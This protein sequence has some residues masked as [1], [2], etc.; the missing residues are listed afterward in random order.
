MITA[1]KQGKMVVMKGWPGFNWTEKEIRNV[2]YETLLARAKEN[3][4]FPLACFLVAAQEHSYFCYTWGYRE[5]HGSLDWYDEFE[6]PL[7]SP[8]ADAI[9]NGWI[10]RRSF[11]HADVWVNL[12]MK[13]AKID[14]Y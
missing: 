5:N 12:E 7:G 8:K 11:E 10:Y 4:T 1:G 9:R 3:M 13:E 2:P 6:K 14:W